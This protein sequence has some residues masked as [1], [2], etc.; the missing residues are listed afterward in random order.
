MAA[1]AV[2]IAYLA[3]IFGTQ[4]VGAI[5]GRLLTA[6]STAGIVGP[7]IVNY[8]R[9]AQIAA[10]VPRDLVYD[11]TMYILAGMLVVGFV[12]NFLIR[13]LSSRWFM[14]D[15]EVARLQAHSQLATVD[16]MGIGQWRL[17][18]TSVMAW[19]A[20]GIPVAWGVWITLSKALVLFR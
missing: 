12:C 9:E 6:W 18:A 7:V 13:P 20:V 10:G 2:W 19:L 1:A 3:D 5:H 15:D 14:S 4:F 8:I 11:F 17:D 16:S